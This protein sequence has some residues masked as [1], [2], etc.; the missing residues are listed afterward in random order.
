MKNKYQVYNDQDQ[1]VFFAV[2]Q[3]GCCMRQMKS[4]L[5]EC[6]PWEVDVLYTERGEH[7]Y[8]SDTDKTWLKMERPTTCTCCCFNRPVVTITDE[9]SGEKL[10]SIQDPFACFDI[11]FSLKD[12]DDNEVYK[13]HGG[14]CQWGLCCPLPCG[15]CREVSFDVYDADNDDQKVG[16]LSKVVP[17]C[18]TW[19]CA[20]DVDDYK[21]EFEGEDGQI[22]DPKHKALLMALAIFMDFRYFNEATHDT[23]GDAAADAA[24]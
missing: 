9:L 13:V 18:C 7:F 8:N 3:T 14:C 17:S 23:P 1:P 12:E 4:C 6:A 16:H 24:S 19:C 21:V 10:G 11:T 22:E 2:E 20:A 15:P 5:G